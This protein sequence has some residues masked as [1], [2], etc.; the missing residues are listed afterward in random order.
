MFHSIKESYR[1]TCKSSDIHCSI[2]YIYILTS[3]LIYHYT[4]H[5]NIFILKFYLNFYETTN[6]QTQPSYII[7]IHIINI[8]I[9]RFMYNLN[10][11]MLPSMHL[12]CNTSYCHFDLLYS[13]IYN[14]HICIIKR[15]NKN[16]IKTTEI[17][18]NYFYS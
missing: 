17:V 16:E 14:I 4:L 6:K 2:Q 10:I 18:F 5:Y 13:Y 9:T 15:W 12:F 8:P 7:M 3:R 1:L 11:Y